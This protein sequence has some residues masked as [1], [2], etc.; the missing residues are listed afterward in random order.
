[1]NTPFPG[2]DPWLEHP[3]LWPDV[4]NS[5][6]AALRDVIAP[7]VA[8]RYF[9]ALERRAYLLDGDDIVLVG[10]PDLS[11]AKEAPA[12]YVVAETV[13]SAV[14]EVDLPAADEVYENY[15]ALYAV[16]ERRLITLIELL[17]PVNKVN[18]NRRRQYEEKRRQVLA[19]QTNLVEID[20]LR[21]GAPMP[22]VGKSV[23][24]DYRLL[25]SRGWQRPR[26]YLYPFALRHPIP[27]FPL[28]LQRGE[29]EPPIPLNATLH[30]L[31][32]R[33]HYDLEI[34]YMLPPEPPL[35][36]ADAAWAQALLAAPME[37]M[38]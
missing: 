19:T 18:P 22:V 29:E 6:I 10:R 32:S 36:E 25:V 21:A 17:S 7:L 5:L 27:D 20:L 3:A 8:P 35:G 37:Q 26:G 15:L 13:E 11:V 9:V 28:P 30:G 24:S 4:H 38:P 12:P 16:K 23:Q 31:Y 2:M 1:M 33:A 14:L 34:D